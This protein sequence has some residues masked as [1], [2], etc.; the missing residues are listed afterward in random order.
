MR[1]P[2]QTLDEAKDS[3]TSVRVYDHQIWTTSVDGSLRSYDVRMGLSFPRSINQ[4]R[5]NC[6]REP[7]LMFGST[8]KLMTTMIHHPLTSLNISQDGNCLLVTCLDDKLRLIDRSNGEPLSE[9]SG[10]RCEGYK[11]EGCL[12]GDDAFVVSGSA[13]H[14]IFFW[15]LIDSSVTQTLSGH[16]SVVCCVSF[17]PTQPILLSSSADST[18]RVW[19]RQEA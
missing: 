13:D 14:K 17:H 16:R 10:H 8:G 4:T 18:I 7:I 2:I 6:D 1:V 12:T 11:I 3:V 19:K 9:Y 5:E 15:N